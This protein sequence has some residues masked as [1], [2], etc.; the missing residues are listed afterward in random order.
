MG[1]EPTQAVKKTKIRIL[2]PDDLGIKPNLINIYLHS[3]QRI[4]QNALKSVNVFFD[5]VANIQKTETGMFPTVD[6]IQSNKMKSETTYLTQRPM[7]P[8]CPPWEYRGA[9]TLNVRGPS[10]LGLTRSISWLLMPW[11]LAS[12]GHQQPWYW[13]CRIGRSLSYSGRNF[14]YLCLISVEEWH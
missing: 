9:L 10:Q 8:R 1:A 2:T 14:N 13:L 6:E 7:P 12:P 4:L 11:L 5:N 3:I